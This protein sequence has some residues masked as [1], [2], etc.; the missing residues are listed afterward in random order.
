MEPKPAEPAS[1]RRHKAL[2][3]DLGASVLNRKFL[4]TGTLTPNLRFY[5]L[6][7]FPVP[8]V[9]VEFYPL[10]LIRDDAPAG[11]GLEL[12]VGAAPFLQSRLRTTTPIYRL[13]TCGQD[14]CYPTSATRVDGGLRF[15][16]LPFSS[17]AFAI[18]PYAGI[19][20]HSFVL[21]PNSEGRRLSGLPNL[22]FLGFRGGLALEIPIVP[23]Y[24]IFFGRFGAI[25]V[26]N[27]ADLISPNFFVAGNTFGMEANAGLGV[28]LTRFLEVR[29]SF[30]FT[31]FQTTFK[32][33]PTDTYIA[34]TAADT[35]L[36]GN[37]SLRFSF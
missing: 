33:S 20:W 31:R 19:R 36:G 11:L 5:D 6:A 25:P 16:F 24:L 13:P 34:T 4:Y 26:F 3:I 2:V 23:G 15:R 22:H 12:T 17:Y 1:P 10:A 18:V 8:T 37:L 27:A 30:E 32:T 7:I 35:Y 28:S 21:G 29:G 14:E 9:G